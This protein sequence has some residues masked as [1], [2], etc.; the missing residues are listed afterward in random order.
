MWYGKPANNN[1]S[2][3]D[4]VVSRGYPYD[5]AW[6]HESLPLGNGYMGVNVFGRTD[7]ERIQVSEKTLATKGPY[8]GRGNFTSFMEVY[9]NFFHPSTKGYRRSLRLNDALATVD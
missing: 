2:T 8:N 6:E 9:L 3:Y 1:G 7:V 5:E 4:F